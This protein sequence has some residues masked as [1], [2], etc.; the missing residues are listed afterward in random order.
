MAGSG[1]YKSYKRADAVLRESGYIKAYLNL[2]SDFTT[3]N[4]PA[5]LDVD[6]VTG[7]AKKITTAHTWAATKGPMELYVSQKSL[8]APAD[9]V[10]NPGSLKFVYHL[11][12]FLVGDGPVTQDL[13]ES[14]LNEQLIAFVQDQCQNGMVLQFGC[15]CLTGEVQKGSFS[16]GTLP[17]G[18][19]GWSFTIDFYCRYFYI[20]ALP[21]SR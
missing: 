17:S 4:E 15:D 8:E 3:L 13:A 12:F 14:F 7:D 6:S 16:S 18:D 20:P 21:A 10:G 11:N 19:K 1:I 2:L 9:T 5:A